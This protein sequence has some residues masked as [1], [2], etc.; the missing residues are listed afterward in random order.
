MHSLSRPWIFGT[1]SR[2]SND[3]IRLRTDI[4]KFSRRCMLTEV[5]VR[6]C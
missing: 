4:S 3:C 1:R 2:S 6:R 5:S